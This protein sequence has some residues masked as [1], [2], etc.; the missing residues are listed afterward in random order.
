M[1]SKREIRTRGAESQWQFDKLLSDTSVSGLAFL[2]QKYK[3]DIVEYTSSHD[4]QNPEYYAELKEIQQRYKMISEELEN[5]YNNTI[6]SLLV[7]KDIHFNE[8]YDIVT[9]DDYGEVVVY[10]PSLT[11]GGNIEIIE[12]DEEDVRG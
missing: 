10:R 6:D 5:R 3:N 4:L 8:N 11:H 7:S 2:K 9:Q 12:I 1:N